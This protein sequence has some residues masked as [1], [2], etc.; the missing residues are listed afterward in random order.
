MYPVLIT[1]IRRDVQSGDITEELLLDREFTEKRL[2]QATII[3]ELAFMREISHLLTRFSK[4]SQKF[5]VLPFHGMMY[6]EKVILMLLAAKER[7]QKG[8]TPVIETINPVGRHKKFQLWF[9]F[10]SC[11]KNA[12]EMQTFHDFKLLL[13]SERGRVSRSRTAFARQISDYED[14]KTHCFTK[15]GKYLDNLIYQLQIR[16]L[17]WPQWLIQCNNCFNF[18]SDVSSQIRENSFSL[19]LG[20]DSGP[21]PLLEEEKRRLKAE[22]I[23]LALNASDIIKESRS[24]LTPE[25]IWYTLLTDKKYY[26]NC[27]LVN[28][29]ALRFL[30]RSFNECV[31]EV[32]VSTISSIDTSS[33]TLSHTTTQNLTFI[34]SN[35]PHPLKA[36]NVIEES[37]NLHFDGKP[38]HFVLSNSKYFVSRVVDRLL[39]EADA[40][41]NE[42]A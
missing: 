11:A 36:M 21:V 30:T 42:L 27:L 18:C 3:L 9:D 32:Q 2:A 28:D 23:T 12:V 37:L 29:F 19:L 4:S 31:V 17:P 8:E 22:Y 33:R 7:I 15:F 41:P 13:P 1:K 39:K 6:Y 25:N 5:D 26:E 14:I 38:W 16:F 20:E 34:S 35:G 40:L 10:S 24:P